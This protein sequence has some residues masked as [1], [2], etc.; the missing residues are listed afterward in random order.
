MHLGYVIGWVPRHSTCELSL[1]LLK[2]SCVRISCTSCAASD[3]PVVLKFLDPMLGR[4]D[5]VRYTGD[6]KG[7]LY[8][9][10]MNLSIVVCNFS[11][12]CKFFF[13]STNSPPIPFSLCRFMVMVGP[14]KWLVLPDMHA[15]A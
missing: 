2:I 13:T 1:F 11:V 5:T 14:T 10:D 12:E 6:E 7:I 8:Q 3:R 4:Y 9:Q 15:E